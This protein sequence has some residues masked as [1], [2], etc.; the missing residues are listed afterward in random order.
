MGTT[1]KDHL[2]EYGE[3]PKK[4]LGQV[5]LIERT[6]QRK[7]LDLADLGPEDTV[8]EIGPG[9]GALTREMLG[10]VRRL[11][12]LEI[13]PALVSFLQGSLAPAGPLWLLCMDALDFPY[14]RAARCLQ[15]RLK[16]VGNIPYGI[17]APLMFAFLDQ[18]ESF[19]MLVLMLQKEVAERLTAQP[20]TKAYGM[21][22]A[23]SGIRFH[24]RI[25]QK[26]SRHC[27]S[28]V[29]GVDSAVIQ[30]IPR[31]EEPVHPE[32]DRVFRTV[33]KAAFSRRRKTLF[34]ALRSS[35]FL[36]V[37]D[38]RLRAALQAAGIDPGRRPETLAPEEFLRLARCI[39]TTWDAQ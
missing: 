37:E 39:P 21:L 26:V 23:L 16:V 17:S 30:C 34:N 36:T 10:R 2:R 12:A 9:T 4:R 1:L 18:W 20:G 5:F 38:S 13:D 29:P 19:A 27:F 32:E 22:T 14:L 33:V 15:T 25:R 31:R 35:P 7:I 24:M 6:I 11:I 3:R 8:V 28:P